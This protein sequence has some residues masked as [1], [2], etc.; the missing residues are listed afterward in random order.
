MEVHEQRQHHDDRKTPRVLFLVCVELEVIDLEKERKR[1]CY[2]EHCL[3]YQNNYWHRY[4]H[5]LLVTDPFEDFKEDC[6]L[7]DHR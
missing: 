1:K 4:E 5:G 3:A 6:E 2:V 7:Q